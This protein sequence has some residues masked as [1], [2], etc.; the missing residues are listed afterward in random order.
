MYQRSTLNVLFLVSIAL[1]YHIPHGVPD[2]A[3]PEHHIE[4]TDIRILSH[5]MY[6]SAHSSHDMHMLKKRHP[7]GHT[8]P[9]EDVE[10]R[11]PQSLHTAIRNGASDTFKTQKALEVVAKHSRQRIQTV[12]DKNEQATAD[13]AMSGDAVNLM[14]RSL[15]SHTSINADIELVDT[16]PANLNH[17]QATC[18]EYHQRLPEGGSV[19]TLLRLRAAC[20]RIKENMRSPLT[21]VPGYAAHYLAK[22]RPVTTRQQ[23]R[24][25]QALRAVAKH[26]HD[27]IQDARQK[28]DQATANIATTR[29]MVNSWNRAASSNLQPSQATK[30]ELMDRHRENMKI[31]ETACLELNNLLHAGGPMVTLQKLRAA[32]KSIRE[33]VPNNGVAVLPGAFLRLQKRRPVVT[34]K[35]ANDITNTRTQPALN[36]VATHAYD[37]IQRVRNKQDRAGADLALTGERAKQLPYIS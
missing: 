22:R 5:S 17:V 15:D 20:K 2:R 25:Q 11:D 32:C 23:A 31:A 9:V 13:K 14:L 6:P 8:P 16:H 29:Q 18:R 30:M 21:Q 35:E 34:R 37:R 27:R 19:P 4:A 3:I 24:V 7:A 36:V 26:S 28:Q 33:N 1:A 12:V 10:R